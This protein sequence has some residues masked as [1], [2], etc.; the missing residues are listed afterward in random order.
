MIEL[1][2]FVK[3]YGS[4]RAVD[5]LNLRIPGGEL[6]GFIGPNG[7]GKT[8]TIRFLATLIKAGGGDGRVAGYSVTRQPLE[9]R[10][11][12]GYM[13][14]QFGSY[15]GMRVH[16]FLD[17]FALAYRLPRSFR[18][19]RIEL[20]LEMLDLAE[21]RRARVMDL[22]RGMK[23]K[24]YLAK[25]LVHDPP[26]LILDEPAAGLDPQARIELK[27]LLKELRR[28]GKTILVSSHILSELADFCT[29]VGIIHRGRLL[30]YGPMEDVLRSIRAARRIAVRC[31]DGHGGLQQ[32]RAVVVNRPGV[33]NVH[34]EDGKLYFDL[35][36]GDAEAADLLNNLIRSGVGVTSFAECDPTLEDVFLRL[37]K[38]M[39]HEAEMTAFSSP[40]A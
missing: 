28:Q 27:R 25:T 9:V 2:D 14:D 10:H 23:Q 5:R 19:R 1:M 8:T 39:S 31:L 20:L 21:K 36:G 12:I 7:A 37:T 24:L 32:A 15:N 16:E 6:F 17:F 4:F 38:P 3:D 11:H 26:V 22:S 30:S 18:K 13:P 29:W 34:E 35:Y 33:E 40:S